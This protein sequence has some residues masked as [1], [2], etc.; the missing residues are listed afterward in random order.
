MEKKRKPE[1]EEEK[2]ETNEAR[3]TK[4]RLLY[5]REDGLKVKT[6][7]PETDILIQ[8]ISAELDLS[9][10]RSLKKEDYYQVDNRSSEFYPE[11]YPLTFEELSMLKI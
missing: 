9:L 2:K 1:E 5:T 8:W 11:K 4:S 10:E 7:K 6:R 3:T